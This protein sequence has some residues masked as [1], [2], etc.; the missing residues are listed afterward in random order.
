M[1]VSAAA[2]GTPGT[3]VLIDLSSSAPDLP[4]RL[5]V[6]VF[7]PMKVLV[8]EA[9]LQPVELPGLLRLQVPDVVQNL[10]VVVA[11][12]RTSGLLGAATALTMPFTSVREP[13]VLSNDPSQDPDGDGIPSSVDNCPNDYNPDQSNSRGVGPGDA[14][15]TRDAGI[16]GPTRPCYKDRLPLCE[17]FESGSW[18]A[19][20]S[21]L[22]ASDS[23]HIVVDGTRPH[24][25][26]FALHLTTDASANSPIRALLEEQ[27]SVTNSGPMYMRGYF[28][29]PS[30]VDTSALGLVLM[31]L[32]GPNGMGL[33]LQVTTNGT[34]G[35]S[36]YSFSPG[37]F[38]PTTTALPRDRFTCLEWLLWPN[39]SIRIWLDGNEI[40]LTIDATVSVTLMEMGWGPRYFFTP[41]AKVYPATELWVDDIVID[42]ARIGCN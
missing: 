25:G 19:A 17:D 32:D 30:S 8:D 5:T 12:D 11:S 20:W 39:N 15:V 40:P 38:G 10:R 34:L 3:S 16:D 29:L 23:G 26:M 42:S 13:I 22:G 37:S 31:A 33:E 24:G 21:P 6:S 28:Y 9:P 27:L 2:C 14:C 35:I 4:Q 41:S 36:N 18:G 1:A 7:D